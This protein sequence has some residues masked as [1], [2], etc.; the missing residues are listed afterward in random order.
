MSD[1]K[2]S[3]LLTGQTALITGAGSGIGRAIAIAYGQEKVNVAVNYHT[4][5]SEAEEVVQE[6]VK[7]G[8]N[9]IKIKADVSKEQDVIEMFKTA[10]GKFGG[11]DI[12]VNNAGIEI[13]NSFTEMTLA[14]WQHVIDINLTGYF[15]CAREAA[16]IFKTKKIQNENFPA[17][18]KMVF[19]SS[20][21]DQIPWAGHANYTASKGGVMMLM[22]SIAQELAP[23]KI[24]V[25]SISPGAIKTHI[26]MKAWATPEAENKLIELIPYHRVGLPEDIAKIAVWLASDESDYLTGEI[27]YADG[28]M[29][30]YPSFI[31][32]G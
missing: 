21:H 18:G 6:I 2:T 28:G 3:G 27:I 16:R 26:N 17:V 9:A 32:G 22:K 14:Q 23:H 4:D 20:V 12:L 1:R 29:M 25:N 8:A 19:I 10:V 24:R 15:L 30:L 13:N 7:A 31:H 5:D 11:L